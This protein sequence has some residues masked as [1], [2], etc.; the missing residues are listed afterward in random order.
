VLLVALFVG[1]LMPGTWKRSAEVALSAPGPLSM[2]AHV[3]LFAGICFLL[4]HARPWRV[5]P[6]H[7][8]GVGLA[9]ALLTE[10]LQFF[11]PGRHPEWAG[12]M[13]DMVGAAI[14]WALGKRWGP[15]PALA[16]VRV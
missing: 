13:Q 15:G 9:L 2:A 3:A 12:V 7:V 11:S 16:T 8:L 10:G 5:V 6:W 1:T 14:G 4:P